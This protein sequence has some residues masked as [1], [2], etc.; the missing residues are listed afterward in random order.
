MTMTC[1][2]GLDVARLRREV[3]ATYAAVALEPDAPFFFHRGPDYAVGTLGYSRDALDALPPEVTRAFAG[4][5]NPHLVAPVAPGDTVVDVGCGSGTD[6]LLAALAV[7]SSGRA[8][9][10]DMTREMRD[11]AARGAA[12]CG[13]S[14][15]EVRD[16]DAADLPVASA[17]AD[18]VQSN[19]VLNLVPEKDRAFAELARILR[20]GGRLRLS[21]IVLGE[22]MPAGA[23]TAVDLWTG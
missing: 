19:G 15:V 5:G 16:G 3:Q 9:G 14:H 11:C 12:A 6:L 23:A 20:P 22:P 2:V 17:S 21:D 13:L 7:G 18:V 1:P 10:L 4:I 8:V